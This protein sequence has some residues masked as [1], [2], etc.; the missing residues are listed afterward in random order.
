MLPIKL[1]KDKT[2]HER[3]GLYIR[4]DLMESLRELAKT[5]KGESITSIVEKFI[6]Y[7]LEQLSKGN[8]NGK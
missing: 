3:V 4:H 5:N 8:G 7:G 6:E 2:K 1:R